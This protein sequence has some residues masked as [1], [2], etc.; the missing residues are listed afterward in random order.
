MSIFR[1]TLAVERSQEFPPCH[2]E[3]GRISDELLGATAA[4]VQ[5]PSGNLINPHTPVSSPELVAPPTIK[6]PKFPR[7]FEKMRARLHKPDDIVDDQK[8]RQYSPTERRSE[9]SRQLT[10]NTVKIEKLPMCLNLVQLKVRITGN[11]LCLV[12][13]LFIFVYNYL[14]NSEFFVYR[15]RSFIQSSTL[16]CGP[17]HFFIL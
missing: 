11:I 5:P 8:M 9:R 13:S 1:A 4:P 16:K 15:I 14:S 12:S 6:H 3:E 2:D 10:G 17:I 7:Q